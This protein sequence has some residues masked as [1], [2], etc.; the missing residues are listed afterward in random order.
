VRNWC[1]IAFGHV[2]LD[3][4]R[5]VTIDPAFWRPDHPVPVVGDT[6][7]L[8]NTLGWAPQ[9][10]FAALVTHMVEA[11]LARLRVGAAV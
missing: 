4:R 6:S 3:W 10:T 9:R 5:H 8:R 7:A 11:D 2:G 1:E